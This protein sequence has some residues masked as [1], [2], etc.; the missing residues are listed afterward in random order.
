MVSSGFTGLQGCYQ[1]FG[2]CRVF[3]YGGLL[4]WVCK[5]F[6]GLLGFW[7]VV[8]KPKEG[9]RSSVR[10]EDSTQ[11]LS[12]G[13]KGLGSRFRLLGFQELRN[14]SCCARGIWVLEI[15]RPRSRFCAIR[16]PLV[17]ISLEGLVSVGCLLTWFAHG[18][19]PAESPAHGDGLMTSG[20]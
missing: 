15:G 19:P 5:D 13:L 12:Y 11:G 7:A 6:A 16:G 14:N 18:C 8:T 17:Y 2:L 10:V 4:Q 20:E 1:G 9:L 3:V